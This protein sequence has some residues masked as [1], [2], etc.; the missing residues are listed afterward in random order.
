MHYL[1]LSITHVALRCVQGERA[2]E[3]EEIRLMENF[4]AT[5]PYQPFAAALVV[6]WLLS[7]ALWMHEVEAAKRT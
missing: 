7:L 4:L 1:L 5:L 6:C 3:S 2:T